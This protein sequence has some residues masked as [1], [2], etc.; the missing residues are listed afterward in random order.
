MSPLE[1]RIKSGFATRLGLW[2]MDNGEMGRIQALGSGAALLRELLQSQYCH[3][4]WAVSAIDI[5]RRQLAARIDLTVDAAPPW[6]WQLGVW[7]WNSDDE[8]ECA[9]G[10]ESDATVTDDD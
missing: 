3:R 1:Q 4:E 7:T 2:L 10:G 6:V 8:E 5:L 9:S